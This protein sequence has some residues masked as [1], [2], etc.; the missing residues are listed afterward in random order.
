MKLLVSTIA[1][2]S[3]VKLNS[4]GKPVEKGQFI[5]AAFLST[6]PRDV[7]S[8]IGVAPADTTT[9][10]HVEVPTKKRSNMLAA[11][12]FAL[13]DSL[14]EEIDQLH[15]TVM[16]WAPDRP[17]QVVIIAR[18][19]I[20]LWLETF[21]SA[22]VKLD[23][24]V[25]EQALLPIHPDSG[26]TLVKQSKNQYAIKTDPYRSFICDQDAFE[27]WW[28]DEKNRQLVIGVNN[29]AF[30]AELIAKGG[31]HVS[32]WAIGDDFRSWLEHAPAQLKS[33]PSLLH[34]EYEPEHLKPDSGWL[35]MAAGLAACALILLGASHWVEA[36]KL[37]QRYD[38]NQ[39]A[40]RVLFDEAFSGEEYLGRPR[41][42]IASLLSISENEP[43]D[44]MFQ[45]L[46]G[47]SAQIA[48]VNK[49][50]LEEINYRDQQLQI[51]V[52]VPNFAALEKLTTQIDSLDGLRAVII[53]SGA[54]DQRVT[55]QIKIAAEGN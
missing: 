15:F 44:E 3:W 20:E 45:Y 8:V 10:H 9:F 6:I 31:D 34:G 32:H 55:G 38:V 5:E 52:T 21:N 42:Q 37:Q 29:H 22:G 17:A 1:P 54:R 30:A 39:Q 49:A 2:Y 24:I 41:R 36:S 53:S 18:K 27:Y 40:I 4:A 28:S 25:P 33:A 51:G 50:E 16:D 47:V 43:A 48:P 11:V 46:L 23:A 13:E 19:T 26:T 12:P 35:N 7:S 14:S